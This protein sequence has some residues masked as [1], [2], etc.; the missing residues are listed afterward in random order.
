MLTNFGSEVVEEIFFP[1]A[2]VNN[3]DD[4]IFEHLFTFEDISFQ[5]N[6]FVERFV[7]PEVA[8]ADSPKF[9]FPD[10]IEDKLE[11]IIDIFVGSVNIL[12]I[13]CDKS[14][15]KLL[16]DLLHFVAPQ[17]LIPTAEHQVQGN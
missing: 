12:L 8:V 4:L 1:F 13:E 3:I 11:I 5:L 7:A 2:I 17:F 6:G 10:A 16:I 15:S 14:F 9:L